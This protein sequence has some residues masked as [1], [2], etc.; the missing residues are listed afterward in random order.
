MPVT[1]KR[2]LLKFHDTYSFKIVLLLSSENH[3]VYEWSA[4][5]RPILDQFS[6]VFIK[7][8]RNRKCF[9]TIVI[10]CNF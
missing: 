5:F 6:M 8:A 1:F 10:F 9:L 3:F 7:T 2:V 4:N